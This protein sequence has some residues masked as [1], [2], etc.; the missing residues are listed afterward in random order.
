M[1][2]YS[3]ENESQIAARRSQYSHFGHRFCTYSYAPLSDYSIKRVCTG[4]G[5]HLKNIV[6]LYAVVKGY[7]TRV[8]KVGDVPLPRELKKE[9]CGLL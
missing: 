3:S 1:A 6:D 2:S 8:H 9:K 4:L 5:L 7:T